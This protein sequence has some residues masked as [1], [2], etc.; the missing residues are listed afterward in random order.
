MPDPQTIDDRWGFLV[1]AA[2]EAL[3]R[4][5]SE[6]LAALLHD[7][8][9]WGSP[10]SAWRRRRVVCNGREEI[11]ACLD[12]LVEKGNLQMPGNWH[13]HEVV[14]SGDLVAVS[15]SWRTPAQTTIHHGHVLRLRG[16]C[17]VEIQ[18]YP[19]AKRALTIVA[20]RERPSG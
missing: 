3:G 2:Y 19:R 15:V 18:S 16:D 8:A 5:E 17:V 1:R 11:R 7:A 9:E 6:A 20:S 10:P 4:G 12:T 14:Q 13:V